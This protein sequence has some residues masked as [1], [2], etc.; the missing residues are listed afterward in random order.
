M[1]PQAWFYG[2]FVSAGLWALV[3]L[4]GFM[5]VQASR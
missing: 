3:F 5:I 4:A 1:S 2:I